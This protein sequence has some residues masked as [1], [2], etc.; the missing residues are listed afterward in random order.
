MTGSVAAIAERRRPRTDETGRFAVLYPA[1]AE[2]ARR[3]GANAL[4]LIDVG[5]SAGFNL[6]VD[7]VGIAYGDHGPLLG[8]PSS[9]VQRSC[10]IVGDRPVPAR[11]IPHVV[12]RVGVDAEPLDVTDAEDA[13]WLRAC[14]WPD[15]PE[16]AAG[17]EAEIA[18]TATAAPVLL[19]GDPVEALPD[20]LAHVPADALPVVL[21]TWAL[22]GF[23][24][25][26]RLRILDRLGDAAAGRAVAWVSAE[27]VGVAPAIP[28]L[29]DR[30]ASGHS[31]LG[32]AM[33]DRSGLCAEAIGRCWSRGSW[34]EWLAGATGGR[35]RTAT[36]ISAWPSLSAV[37]A[38]PMRGWPICPARHPLRRLRAGCRRSLPRSPRPT[39][40]ACLRCAGEPGHPRSTARGSRST[41][42]RPARRTS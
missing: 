5:R 22:P 7:R 14:V 42:R 4:G 18:L 2:A 32:L 34:L 16:R 15:Q 3:A 19:R 41:S 27:G 9:P 28:A 8:D 10:S 37:L 11:A 36:A 31:I 29:G 20:A 24:R 25:E 33:L 35:P 38:A 17:L 30:R 26:R 13:R 12:A 23:P 6:I 21:T 1:V 40:R 39:P